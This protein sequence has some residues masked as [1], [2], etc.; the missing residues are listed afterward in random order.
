MIPL[1]SGGHPLSLNVSNLPKNIAKAFVLFNAQGSGQEEFW[2]SNVPSN[3]SQ[4]A[5]AYGGT[6]FRA[7]KV[8][9]NESP[10]MVQN[11]VPYLFTGGDGPFLWI[12]T[13]GVQTLHLLM[14]RVDI[15]PGFFFERDVTN[16]TISVMGPEVNCC[17]VLQASLFLE[18]DDNVQSSIVQ[19][20][21]LPQALNNTQVVIEDNVVVDDSE[22]S[23]TLNVSFSVSF[24]Q[25]GQTKYKNGKNE[26]VESGFD[27]SFFN[28]QNYSSALEVKYQQNGKFDAVQRV[29]RGN[30]VRETTTFQSYPLRADQK[31]IP[32]SDPNF[33][34]YTV[35]F[36]LDYNSAAKY[37]ESGGGPQPR[38]DMKE[39]G[40]F[41]QKILYD[42]KITNQVFATSSMTIDIPKSSVTYAYNSASSQRYSFED[43][44]NNCY[45]KLL[46][47]VNN[48]LLTT[49]VDCDSLQFWVNPFFT[50]SDRFEEPRTCSNAG[51]TRVEYNATQASS[52]SDVLSSTL[53]NPGRTRKLS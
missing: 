36:F 17:W 53:E 13:P 11:V 51:N 10:V 4:A 1:G 42:A 39:C 32:Q 45:Q 48:E 21:A 31:T 25:F 7:L 22:V 35:T 41:Q 19:R 29:K 27:F 9:I 38:G 23:G 20:N 24:S 52:V 33:V 46:G 47:S 16:L 50:A 49:F 6:A 44:K 18:L 2:W 8:E 43:S 40:R 5:G 3:L 37:V 14:Q 26:E 15:L 12:P 30:I 34:N 28:F